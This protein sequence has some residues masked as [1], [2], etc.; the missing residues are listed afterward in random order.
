MYKLNILKLL[1]FDIWRVLDHRTPVY[2]S[3]PSYCTK[4]TVN[5]FYRYSFVIKLEVERV[6]WVK[7]VHFVTIEHFFKSN[8]I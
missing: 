5:M 7:R 8:K 2:F 3:D 1:F 4:A 6:N